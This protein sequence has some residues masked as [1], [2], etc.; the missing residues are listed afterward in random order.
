M[1]E[2]LAAYCGR[3][4]LNDLLKQWNQSENLPMSPQ[5]VSYGSKR[6][7]WWQCE[8][9]HR[10]KAAVYTRIA[11]TGCPYCAGKLPLAGETDLSTCYPELALE[12]HPTKNTPLTAEQVLPGSHRKVWW[13]CKKGHE[14]QAQ[15]KSRVSGCGCP[16]CADRKIQ[17][18]ENDFAACFPQV[19]TQWHPTKNGILNPAALA[20]ASRRKVWW[21]CEKGHE[22]QA[23]VASRTSGGSGCPVCTGKIVV[24]GE[25]D[26]GSQFPQLAAQWDK[27]KN[28]NLTPQNVTA[29]SNRKVW[30]KC[31]LGHQYQA[32][33]ASRTMQGGGCPYCAGKKVLPGFNDLATLF[34]DLAAQWHPTLNGGVRPQMVTAGA[35]RKVWWECSLG[36]VWKAMIYSRTGPKRCGCP[37]CAGNTRKRIRHADPT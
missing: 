12:W 32:A 36:H 8:R 29:Y 13:M 35:H 23:S 17:P 19:A 7:V 18:N 28:G 14:W 5:T 30:W 22:W 16:I 3:N 31:D 15:I 6:K 24:S 20:P 25:N 33:V 21:R 37:I 34:P 10:W 26:L 1:R 9:G 11:G 27:E 4:G 2:M